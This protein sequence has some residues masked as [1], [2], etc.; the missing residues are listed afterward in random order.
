MLKFPTVLLQGL[1]VHICMC[2]EGRLRGKLGREE[3]GGYRSVVHGER[4]R[5]HTPVITTICTVLSLSCTIASFVQMTVKEMESHLLEYANEAGDLWCQLE[6]CTG[7][8]TP[9]RVNIWGLRKTA[10]NRDEGRLMAKQQVANILR[11]LQKVHNIPKDEVVEDV[12]PWGTPPFPGRKNLH[13]I[14]LTP[15]IT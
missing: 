1:Y 3:P 11:H 14:S 6:G 4:E 12:L 13:L 9:Y 7:T 15:N 10:E 2:G 5:G 8:H